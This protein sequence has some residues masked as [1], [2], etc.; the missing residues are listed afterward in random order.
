MRTRWN[1]GGAAREVVSPV[2]L[3]VTA[4]SA[5]ADVRQC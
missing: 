4:F 5:V 2:S 1:I 3:I